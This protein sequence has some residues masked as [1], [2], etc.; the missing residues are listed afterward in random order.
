MHRLSNMTIYL[1]NKNSLIIDDF[2]LRCSIG[3]NGLSKNKVEGDLKTPRF[4]NLSNL[5][6]RRDRNNKPKTK[7][8]CILLINLWAGVMMLKAEITIN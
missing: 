2:I 6:Y 7:L 3:K 5:Y 1:K 8:K 4:Y